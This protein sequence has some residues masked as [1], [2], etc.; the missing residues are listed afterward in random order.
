MS[1][2]VCDSCRIVFGPEATSHTCAAPKPVR[3]DRLEPGLFYPPIIARC[4]D[5]E[6]LQRELCDWFGGDTVTVATAKDMALM[7]SRYLLGR[8]S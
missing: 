5:V 2:W 4:E 3:V 6:G 8:P 7:L 1:L